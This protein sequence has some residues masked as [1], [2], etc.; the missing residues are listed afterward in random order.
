VAEP[1][2]EDGQDKIPCHGLT[3]SYPCFVSAMSSMLTNHRPR[4]AG[5]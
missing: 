3:M 1:A 5:G 2:R 4:Y